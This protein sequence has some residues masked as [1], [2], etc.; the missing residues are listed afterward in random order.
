ML[1]SRPCRARCARLL[2]RRLWPTLPWKRSSGGPPTSAC[3][4][5]GC[6]RRCS[7][8]CANEKG[9]SWAYATPG[10]GATLAP[11]H[12]KMMRQMAMPD[13][14]EAAKAARSLSCLLPL[15][16]RLNNDA[17][18]F[19]SLVADHTRRDNI[20]ILWAD[21]IRKTPTCI[22]L[23]SAPFSALVPSKYEEWTF[24]SG[25]RDRS[26]MP[27]SDDSISLGQ[28]TLSPWVSHTRCAPWC[29][30]RRAS[31]R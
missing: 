29:A 3:L 15:T 13:V 22:C 31:R 4:I 14:D 26:R 25:F 11:S 7:S 21:F 30:R 10:F 19:S 1:H 8:S 9:A 12:L 28:S 27:F 16:F 24:L 6:L 5:G 2:L 18:G 23:P 17:V 20:V